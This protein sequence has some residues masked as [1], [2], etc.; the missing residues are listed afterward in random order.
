MSP[1]AIPDKATLPSVPYYPFVL[2]LI[3]RIVPFLGCILLSHA[4]F[5]SMPSVAL[6]LVC[7]GAEGKRTKPKFVNPPGQLN[8]AWGAKFTKPLFSETPVFRDALVDAFNFLRHVTR[9]TWSVRPKCSHRCVSLKET[10]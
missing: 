4:V 3:V 10:L 8:E 2:A 9:A 1:K 7:R 6:F 5:C